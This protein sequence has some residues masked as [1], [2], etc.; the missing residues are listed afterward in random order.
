M[1]APTLAEMVADFMAGKR[2][3]A[4]RLSA[5]IAAAR[6]EAFD[7]AEKCAR[8]EQS[9]WEAMTAHHHTDQREACGNVAKNIADRI[10]AA[11]R[12]AK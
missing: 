2:V 3:T 7:V 4:E 1:T 8:R 11:A 10:A 6:V 9:S 12:E 5:I